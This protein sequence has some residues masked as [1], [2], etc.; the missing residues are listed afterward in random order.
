MKKALSMLCLIA[1][2]NI[3][4]L[5][6]PNNGAPLNTGISIQEAIQACGQPVSSNQSQ[7]TINISEQLV[8]YKNVLGKNIKVTLTFSYGKLQNIN[9]YDSSP[10]TQTCQSTNQLG[11]TVNAPCNPIEENSM[12][13]GI[14]GALIQAGNSIDAVRGTCGTPSSDT[15]SSTKTITYQELIYNSQ[16]PNKL[17]FE[18]G[19]LVDWTN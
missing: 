1:S 17:I 12:T 3:Y 15:V 5:S 13:S 18:D 4:A 14:C 19:K 10:T 8:Y 16:G 9:T 2:S 6:C 11:Q 7:K